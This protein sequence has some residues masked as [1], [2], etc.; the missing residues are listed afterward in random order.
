MRRF[1]YLCATNDVVMD[2][3]T[4]YPSIFQQNAV[5]L[6]KERRMTQEDVAREI[7]VSRI[8][9][10]KLERG[11]TRLLNEGVE[12]LARLFDIPE[13]ELLFGARKEEDAGAG[14]LEE[15]EVP[16]GSAAL[17][18]QLA[19]MERE[20][21]LLKDVIKTLQDTIESQREMIALLKEKKA[22]E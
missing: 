9:Y 11:E 8:S 22:A 5:K 20:I 7:G 2:T 1:A 13:D 19:S 16:Y 6:R 18:R 21:S 3:K 4:T 17:Q 12:K 14:V 15:G 10:S